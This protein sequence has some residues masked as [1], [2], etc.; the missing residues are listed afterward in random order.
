MY[1]T[2]FRATESAINILIA[3]QRECED[4]YINAPE[5]ELNFVQLPDEEQLQKG[6]CG[7][8]K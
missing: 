1:Q 3:A 8:T 6:P 4:L 2:L 7:V 5:S